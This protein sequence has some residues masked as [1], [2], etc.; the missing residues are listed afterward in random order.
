MEAEP[1]MR[2]VSVR[3][4]AERQ[5]RTECRDR[6]FRRDPICRRCLQADATQVH[7]LARGQ[8]RQFCYL[9]PDA[10]LGLCASCHR[11]VS[12]NPADAI[13]EGWA[14]DAGTAE[15]WLTDRGLLKRTTTHD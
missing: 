6:V 14:W 5:A 3:R 13:R 2:A 15:R 4:Q 11:W 12:L 8:W 1:V 7:E 9:E 10:C